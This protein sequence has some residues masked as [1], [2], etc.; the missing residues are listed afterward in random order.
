MGSGYE[1]S[2]GLYSEPNPRLNLTVNDRAA[3]AQ[4]AQDDASLLSGQSDSYCMVFPIQSHAVAD[5]GFP[6]GGSKVVRCT[7]CP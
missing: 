4:Y 6:K 1:T 2:S 7:Q 3:S 5:L